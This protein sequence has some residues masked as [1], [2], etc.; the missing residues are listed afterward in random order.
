MSLLFDGFESTKSSSGLTKDTNGRG[1][2]SSPRVGFYICGITGGEPFLQ[3]WMPDLLADVG[4]ILPV[5]VL[6]N[7]TMLT[8]DEYTRALLKCKDL[9]VQLQISVDD[10]DPQ[11]HDV[12]RG[13]GS[14]SSCDSGNPAA[15][16]TWFIRSNFQHPKF[17]PPMQ[18]NESTM[19]RCVNG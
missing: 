4:M 18:K 1:S 10:P 14:F 2:T 8:P 17:Y 3:P 12:Q 6:T 15:C 13:K 9:P 7:G 19:R 5:I 11:V 16:K